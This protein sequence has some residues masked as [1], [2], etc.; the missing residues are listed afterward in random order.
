MIKVKDMPY[1]RLEKDETIAKINELLDKATTEG[2][3]PELQAQY[4]ALPHHAGEC[5]DCEACVSRC[6]FDVD[7]PAKMDKAKEIF[8][9]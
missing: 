8:G 5:T 2:L 3:T 6:P 4:D 7:I 9:K 1:S